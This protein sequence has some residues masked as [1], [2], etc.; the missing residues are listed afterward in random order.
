M[1]GIL[2]LQ[3]KVDNL[4]L[5]LPSVSNGGSS[6]QQNLK[7]LTLNDI[8]ISVKTT[9]SYLESRVRII[10]DTWFQLAKQQVTFRLF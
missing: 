2:I 7:H 4:Q 3:D 10:V 9:N 6:Y 8:F 1:L 5:L